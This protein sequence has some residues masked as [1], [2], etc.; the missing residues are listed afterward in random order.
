MRLF[1]FFFF[2]MKLNFLSACF[3]KYIYIILAIFFMLFYCVYLLF[4]YFFAD[5]VHEAHQSRIKAITPRLVF[6]FYL[7]SSVPSD[8]FFIALDN[9]SSDL[10]FGTE[11]VIASRF[12]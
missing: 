10:F 2:Y 1:F 3:E 11:G 8:L 6:Q 9:V 4:F 12:P 5:Q 7:L